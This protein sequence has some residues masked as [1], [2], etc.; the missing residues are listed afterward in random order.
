MKST[1]QNP[2]ECPFEAVK[3][4]NFPER[5]AKMIDSVCVICESK[6]KFLFVEIKIGFIRKKRVIYIF[7]THCN[8]CFPSKAQFPA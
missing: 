8:T 6:R 7:L 2:Q 3:V 5:T 4:H 1:N